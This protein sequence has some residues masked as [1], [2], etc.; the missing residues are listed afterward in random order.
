MFCIISSGTQQNV[1][2]RIGKN[3]DDWEKFSINFDIKV[4]FTRIYLI[5]T[6]W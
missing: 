6:N 3:F 2:N 4:D 1:S 5:L